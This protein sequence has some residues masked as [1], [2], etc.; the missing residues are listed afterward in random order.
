MRYYV[1]A[2]RSGRISEVVIEAPDERQAAEL[3]IEYHRMHVLAI[4]SEQE[5]QQ[6]DEVIE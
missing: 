1:T 6:E 5:R 2:E 3:A 4:E